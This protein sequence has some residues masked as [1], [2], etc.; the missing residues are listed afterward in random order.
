MFYSGN[1]GV[2]MSN[3]LMV[4]EK[5]KYMKM[6]DNM[7]FTSDQMNVLFSKTPDEYI[8]TREGR[9]NTTLDYVSGHYVMNVLNYVFAFGWDFEIIS[10]EREE[11]DELTTLGK[12]SVLGKDGRVISKT[13]YGGSSIKKD[14][15]GQIISI[16]DDKKASATDALKKCASLFGVAWDVYGQEDFRQMKFEDKSSIDKKADEK[17]KKIEDLIKKIEA[18]K[19]GDELLELYKNN[20]E[21]ATVKELIVAK[22]KKK[23]ELMN[24]GTKSTTKHGRVA[25]VPAGENRRK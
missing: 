20:R 13:Q 12:L 17:N 6:V 18:C 24:E 21:I 2:N 15:K 5:D 4:V 7:P 22:N 11:N 8:R 23:E 14:K 19:T 16:S 9:G 10:T 1:E 3:K 25:R